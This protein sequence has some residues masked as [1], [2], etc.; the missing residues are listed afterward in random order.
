MDGDAWCRLKSQKFLNLMNFKEFTLYYNA[1][2]KK[3]TG[4]TTNMLKELV[5]I[6]NFLICILELQTND[7]IALGAYAGSPMGVWRWTRWPIFDSTSVGWPANTLNN[8]G[9]GLRCIG[10]YINQPDSAASYPCVYPKRIIC[11]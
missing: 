9:D 3:K 2:E 7:Y 10:F 6:T 8:N 5:Y 1:L 11:Q 4:S